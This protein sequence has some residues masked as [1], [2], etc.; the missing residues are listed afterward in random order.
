MFN[1]NRKYIALPISGQTADEVVTEALNDIFDFYSIVPFVASELGT[2]KMC[3]LAQ[4]DELVQ[5]GIFV[6]IDGTT[7]NINLVSAGRPR[8]AGNIFSGSSSGDFVLEYVEGGGFG[9]RRTDELNKQGNLTCLLTFGI[10]D[11][12][13]PKVFGVYGMVTGP[14]ILVISGVNSY[15]HARESVLNAETDIVSLVPLYLFDDENPGIKTQGLYLAVQF[16]RRFESDVFGLNGRKY[17][18]TPVSIDTS[19]LGY[20]RLVLD[21]TEDEDGES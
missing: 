13:N 12:D 21:V 19:Y 4:E 10:L 8:S 11:S 14:N 9:F 6:G 3:Y 5:T 1:V 17:I 20:Q 16:P 18:S 15:Y 7:L 2:G